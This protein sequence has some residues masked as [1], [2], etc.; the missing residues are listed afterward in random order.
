MRCGG[1][2]GVED[3][4]TGGLLADKVVPSSF[5][6][7][8]GSPRSDEMDGVVGLELGADDYVTKPFGLRELVA[9]IRAVLR[10]RKCTRARPKRDR[11]PSRS[12]FGGWE[13]NRSDGHNRQGE[14][15]ADDWAFS[16]CFWRALTAL[17]I[18]AFYRERDG[19]PARSVPAVPGARRNRRVEGKERQ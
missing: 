4:A 16:T 12:R 2:S 3:L 13:L 6:K 11:E 9:R 19:Y 14:H 7:Q 15:V 17:A 8:S 5:P 1:G 18:I 10:R